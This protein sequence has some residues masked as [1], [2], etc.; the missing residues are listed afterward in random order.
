LKNSPVVD[1]VL[2]SFNRC[3]ETLAAIKNV[4]GQENVQS[5]VW[6]VD[7][8]SESETTATLRN[9]VQGQP[10]LH[11]IEVGRNLGPPGGRNLGMKQGTAEYVIV[12]DNDAEFESP[13]AISITLKRFSLEPELA[14]IGYRILN[15]FTG[16]DD[17]LSWAYPVMQKSM[18]N[19]EFYT[20]R[21][22]G[23]G[24][25]FKREVLVRSG[26]YDESLF[27]YHE[28]I[29]LSFKIIALG[30]KIIYYPSVIVR[31]KVSPGSRVTWKNGRY[32]YLVRNGLFV[33]FKYSRNWGSFFL[34]AIGYKIKGLVNGA[35]FDGLR[36][37]VDGFIMS[38]QF[39]KRND[40]VTLSPENWEY[41]RIN[42]LIFRGNLIDRLR[43]EIFSGFGKFL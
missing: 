19:Q 34:R 30:Y 6:I 28:E 8:G 2:L 9:F 35:F 33:N 20:T 14:V 39:I 36:G 23:C 7:Q 29:D 17:E 1:V 24:H 10:N 16:K 41:I 37:V 12:I 11:L 22:V 15:F 38:R 43:N 31:H 26:F 27:F 42:E 25:A 32:Y 13:D 40:I 18:R 3:S 5:E 21:Y 4:L